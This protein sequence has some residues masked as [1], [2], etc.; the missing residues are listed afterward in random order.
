MNIGC[1]TSAA[2][3]GGTTREIK[4][5]MIQHHVYSEGTSRKWK[6]GPGFTVCVLATM[7]TL[8]SD[9]S[10]IEYEVTQGYLKVMGTF[11][12]NRRLS[13]QDCTRRY[14]YQRT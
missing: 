13:I 5:K 14:G 7:V 10:M 11:Y 3:G 4:K 1:V 12:H 8:I 2:R 9:Q 6:E